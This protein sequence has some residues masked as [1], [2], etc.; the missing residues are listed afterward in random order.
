MKPT[1]QTFIN[2]KDGAK[3]GSKIFDGATFKQAG[4][5][6]LISG[7]LSGVLGGVISKLSH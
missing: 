1:S 6:A 5:S 2:M 4:K 7:A 3:E